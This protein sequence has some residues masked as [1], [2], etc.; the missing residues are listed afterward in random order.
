MREFLK[1]IIRIVLYIIVLSFVACNNQTMPDKLI[2]FQ[3]NIHKNDT[4]LEDL[5]VFADSCTLK[6]RKNYAFFEKKSEIYYQKGINNS[7]K[8]NF[9]ESAKDLFKALE[10]EEN[11]IT[12]KSEANND[13]YHFL[14]Q[15][16]ESIGDVYNK[17]NSLKA[18]SYF[19]DKSLSQYGNAS[20]Q[21]EVIDVLLKIGDL[22]QANHIPNI[23][24]LNY[25]IAE[26]KR[27]LTESQ[28]NDILIRKGIS[29]Y[30]I[31]DIHTADSIYEII[32]QQSLQSVEFLYFTAYHFYNQNKY[33]EALPYLELCF[34]NG[35]Q[36][37]KLNAAEMLADVYFRMGDRSN[38]LQYAQFQAKA[39]S[40][41]AR[42]TPTKMELET[43]YDN[44][45]GKSN[46]VS[47][48]NPTHFTS[49][50]WI[51]L[52]VTILILIG[53]AIAYYISREKNREN[54]QVIQD[55]V[56][57]IDDKEK[58]INEITQKLEIANQPTVPSRSFDEDYKTF[59]ETRIFKEIKDSLEGKVIMTK[60]VGDYPRLA[61]S[62]V[63]LVTL[64]TK[65]NECFPNLTHTLVK[66]HPELTS[67]DTRYII[68][69]VMGFSCLEIA[70]L[71]QLTYS[72]TN[73]RNKH[74]KA[75][76]G[77]EEALE[78]FLANYLRSVRY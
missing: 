37:M 74:I 73:K 40:A 5:A 12:I 1:H 66:L 42:L 68:L 31:Y 19:Y 69:G 59:A 20:R 62:K 76:F 70:V 47:K 21:H 36:N 9:L 24:L 48:E 28:L 15:I 18:A 34:A 43:L 33:K 7:A 14:G 60:T 22:Y 13:D 57:I 3:K 67:N 50:H 10:A 8:N 17:V 56:K 2:N 63:K 46:N 51:L 4:L 65:F 6:Y 35:T 16:Y 39:T 75:V 27:N 58:I 72:S 32:S 26:E 11:S 64:T 77:T 41:E 55:K 53:V 52:S 29:L 25:E 49:I 45:I 30:D 38:E 44:F 54:H 71:L 61:L 78:H 23:A